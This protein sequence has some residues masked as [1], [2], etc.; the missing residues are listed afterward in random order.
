MRLDRLDIKLFEG[1]KRL[2]FA[3]LH[4]P[5]YSL[6]NDESKNKIKSQYPPSIIHFFFEQ[7]DSFATFVV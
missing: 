4:K 5:L 2:H 6:K 7:F 1:M 3:L